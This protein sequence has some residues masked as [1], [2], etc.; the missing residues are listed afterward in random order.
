MLKVDIFLPKSRPF[1]QEEYRRV[2]QETLFSGT[3]PFNCASVEDTLLHKLEWYR[4]G[5]E[6]SDRQWNDI[7]G[8]LKVKGTTLD[9][10]YLHTWANQLHVADLLDRAFIDAGLM[11]A[12]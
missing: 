5:N 2:Q 9:M 8:I 7:L 6:R 12:P 3:R 11:R 4:M 1:D 10:Q